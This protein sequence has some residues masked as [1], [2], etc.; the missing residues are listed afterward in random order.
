MN[1]SSEIN[2][3]NSGNQA[4]ENDFF[5]DL[6]LGKILGI[7]RK[8]L[9]WII[10]LNTLTISLAWLYLRYTKPVY[11]SSSDLKITVEN[12]KNMQALSSVI[13]LG[14]KEEDNLAGELEFMRSE[15]ISNVVIDNLDL[16]VS[17]HA[18]GNILDSELYKKA[19][20]KIT[21]YDLKAK[22]LFD[23]KF[24]VKII[25]ENRFELSYKEGEALIKNTYSFDKKIKTPFFELE[26]TL[27][28]KFSSDYT[29]QNYYFII[30]SPNASKQ[31]IR[32]NLNVGVANKDAKII[33]LRFSDFDPLKA[34]DIVAQIDSVYIVESVKEKNKSNVQQIEYLDSEIAKFEDSLLLYEASMQG[35]YIQNKSKDTDS[36]LQKALEVF[37]KVQ[38]ERQKLT[39]QLVLLNELEG[40]IIRNEDLRDF[41]PALALLANEKVASQI[42]SYRQLVEERKKLSLSQIEGKTYRQDA[43]GLR[44]ESAK[45]NL[46]LYIQ[47]GRRLLNESIRDINIKVAEAEDALLGH[48]SR[49]REFNKISR[50]YTTY[51][52]RF[53]ALLSNKIQIEIAKAGVVPKC[54]ILSPAS[55]PTIPIRPDRLQIYIVGGV[56]G[57]FLSLALVALRY[58]MHNTIISQADL[59]KII[60]APLLGSIPE[61]KKEKMQHTK[62]IVGRNS[63]S[64]INESLRAIRTNMEFMLPTGKGLYDAD[65]CT[66]LSVTSTISGEGKTFVASNL[67]GI[68]ALSNLKVII[69]DFDMRK[70]KLHLAF[71]AQNEQGVSSILIGK[72]TVEECI[73]K[74]EINSLDF[75]S[76]GPTP[77]NPSE[78]I[79]RED[80]DLMFDK[81]R[82]LYDVVIID[83]PPVG[84]VTDGVLIMKKVDMPIYIARANYSKKLFAKNINRLIRAN[85]FL[86]LAVILNSVKRSSGG[87]GGYGNY[88]GYY[89]GYYGGGYYEDHKDKRTWRERISSLFGRKSK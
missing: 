41:I 66:L 8:S 28:G 25:N 13:G 87:Y 31:Y 14:V 78:L 58:L 88:G 35:F 81:L 17:Y 49:S 52:E 38:P 29:Y 2:T 20:F 86:N 61:Y 60:I 7:L 83:T 80:L 11:E 37:E 34:Q 42:E 76:S 39:R 18:K 69:L 10:L 70:P 71:D 30:N 84:L 73:Q 33:S 1:N 74:T 82:K 3:I 53:N 43:I 50:L 56:A 75:I 79:L 6:D 65:S 46:L 89:G 4:E 16:D 26:I 5:S 51:N 63:K 59:E 24:F 32:N 9:L 68:I 64:S 21:S 27:L 55:L 67:G 36:K 62:L 85:N 15:I 40:L 22:G 48:P 57:L 77:P 19:P 45:E 72:K 47:G 54:I 44:F 23:R 12:E